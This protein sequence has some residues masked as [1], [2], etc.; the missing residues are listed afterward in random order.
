MDPHEI[1]TDPESPPLATVEV[2]GFIPR[3]GAHLI[4][5][6]IVAVVQWAVQ[7]GLFVAID[8][9][10]APP[11]GTAPPAVGMTA[12]AL[13]VLINPAYFVGFWRLRGQTPGKMALGLKIVAEDGSPLSW[14]RAIVRYLGWLAGG[15]V[16]ALGYIW[17][18]FDAKRQGWHD[19]LARTYVV[20]QGAVFPA[21]G[22]VAVVPADPGSQGVV[23]VAV[24]A[25]L[26][27]FVL[28]ILCIV[29]YIAVGNA[30]GQVLTGVYDWIEAA[31]DAAPRP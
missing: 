11:G 19:K 27:F 10:A 18:A 13:V 2:V 22:R 31:P 21:D 7:L 28:P 15:L 1:A 23:A 12:A 16:L 29:L 5:A 6:V 9:L 20:R 3:L 24:L 30:L 4:D 14:G 17:V 25:L 8:V 26:L